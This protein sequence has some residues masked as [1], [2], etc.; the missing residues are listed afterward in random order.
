[1][2]NIESDSYILIHRKV[3]NVKEKSWKVTEFED[4]KRARDLYIHCL[5]EIKSFQIPL[6]ESMYIVCIFVFCQMKCGVSELHQSVP[7]RKHLLLH[8]ISWLPCVEDV[9]KTLK[10]CPTFFVISTTL[11][12]NLCS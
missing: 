3:E 1:M 5:K 7:P 2:K 8:L 4:H 12:N 6:V 10:S 11:V 9:F